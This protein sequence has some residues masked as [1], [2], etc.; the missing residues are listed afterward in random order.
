MNSFQ[1]KG[2]FPLFFIF[3]FERLYFY[4]VRALLILFMLKYLL[5]STE[6]AGDLYGWYIGI[7]GFSPI[8]GGLI[9]D[10][11]LGQRKTLIW[12]VVMAILG[13][14]FLAASSLTSSVVVQANNLYDAG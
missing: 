2:Y 5:F 11:W 6:K 14:V 8:L 3:M 1:P 12:S 10:I 9:A 13:C 4:G 7:L